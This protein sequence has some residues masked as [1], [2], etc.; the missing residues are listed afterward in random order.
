MTSSVTS[1]CSVVCWEKL[2]VYLL[3]QHE[4]LSEC[5]FSDETCFSAIALILLLHDLVTFTEEILNGKVHFS[6]SEFLFPLSLESSVIFYLVFEFLTVS[7][8]FLDDA[9]TG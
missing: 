1:I 8:S 3:H 7:R 5:I 4:Q 6:S 9:N 2:M